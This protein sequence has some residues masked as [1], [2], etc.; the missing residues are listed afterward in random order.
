MIGGLEARDRR[1]AQEDKQAHQS[2]SMEQP[3]KKQKSNE[4][5]HSPEVQPDG[6]GLS[7]ARRFTNEDE[8]CGSTGR[9]DVAGGALPA[10]G[11]PQ[12]LFILAEDALPRGRWSRAIEPKRGENQGRPYTRCT[13][14]VCMCQELV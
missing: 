14:S 13:L 1:P 6:S 11:E 5:T 4:Q 9:Y 3:G 7:T 12:P 10:P 2:G 8:P